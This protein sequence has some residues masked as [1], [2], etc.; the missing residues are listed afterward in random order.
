MVK[1]RRSAPAKLDAQNVGDEHEKEEAP[2]PSRP[3]PIRRRRR[4]GEFNL[5]VV[6]IV[7]SSMLKNCECY[8]AFKMRVCE[9][10]AVGI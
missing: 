6:I 9:T 3:R 1:R 10:T 8:C 2:S 4:F 5:L 7:V